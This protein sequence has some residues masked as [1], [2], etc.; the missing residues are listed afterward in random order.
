MMMLRVKDN[1]RTNGH[2]IE[3]SV[4]EQRRRASI[5]RAPSIPDDSRSRRVL[6]M[7]KENDSRE[8][9]NRS[10]PAGEHYFVPP[11]CQMRW[12]TEAIVKWLESEGTNL[13]ANVADSLRR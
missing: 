10:V 13:F 8:G 11:G 6:A 1:R 12:K 3:G 9:S 5:G 4:V 7:V 2:K